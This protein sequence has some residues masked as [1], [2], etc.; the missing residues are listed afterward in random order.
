MIL[1]V[2]LNAILAIGVVVM[3]VAP[4]VWAILT[5]HRDHSKL[6]TVD[7]GVPAGP[8]PSHARRHA[9]QSSYQSRRRAGVSA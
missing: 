4:L 7:D 6:V 1:A 5:Q 9:P 8:A 3:V 2:V